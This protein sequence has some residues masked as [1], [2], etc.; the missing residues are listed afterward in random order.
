MAGRFDG[1]VALVTGAASGIGEATAKRFA[2]EGAR[3]VVVDLNAEGARRVAGEIGAAGGTAIAVEA[4][5]ATAAGAEAMVGAATRTYGRLDVVHSNATQGDVALVGDTSLTGWERTIGVNLTAPFLAARAALPTMIAQGGGVFVHMSSGAGILA[6]HGF[7]AYGAAKAGVLSLTRSIAI[8]YARHG[9][10]AVAIC[11]GAIATP[12]LV[13][14]ANAVEGAGERMAK[15]SP[16]RRL[17]RPE[18]I[19]AV[20]C[21]LASDEASFMSGTAVVVDG[22]SLATKEINVTGLA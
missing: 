6:E 2:S 12:P 8:E 21:F 17:G 20:V 7:G 11:P 15:A 14:F 13:A 3:V 4:D 9:V 19:A 10:R 22:A 1:R 5:V 16:F 18:E